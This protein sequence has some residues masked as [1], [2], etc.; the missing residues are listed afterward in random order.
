[1]FVVKKSKNNPIL[2]PQTNNYFESF[3]VFNGNPIKVGEQIH[4]LYRA[5]SI[6]ERFENNSFSLSVVGKAESRDGFSFKKREVFIT[7][8]YPWEKFGCEDPRV[9]K[10]EGN[11]FIFYTALSSFPFEVSGIKVGLAISK[12]LKTISEKHLVTPFNAK[13]MTLFP[14]KIN[15]KY[16]AILTANTD[17]PP[18]HIAIAE[19]SELEEIWST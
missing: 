18:S 12:D 16:I 1:M 2:S 19:F 13:A 10:I 8:E 7:P 9:T 3:A 6:P 14:E 11:Y 17:I 4:L 5:Q 15:G